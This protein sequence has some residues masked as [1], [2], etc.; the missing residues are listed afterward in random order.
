MLSKPTL[1]HE[2]KKATLAHEPSLGVVKDNIDPQMMHATE[3]QSNSG[4]YSI[5]SEV[6]DSAPESAHA[7]SRDQ[8][9][10]VFSKGGLIHPPADCQNQSSHYQPYSNNLSLIKSG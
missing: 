9:F 3:R 2:G 1:I 4:T 7:S 10:T 6:R 5:L 8:C